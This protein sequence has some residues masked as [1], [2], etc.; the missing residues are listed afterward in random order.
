MALGS[1]GI[2]LNQQHFAYLEKKF[3]P[4]KIIH[5]SWVSFYQWACW[6]TMQMAAQMMVLWDKVTYIQQSRQVTKWNTHG[7]NHTTMQKWVMYIV[8]TCEEERRI[9]MARHPTSA[10]S[11]TCTVHLLTVCVCVC[12]YIYTHM[13]THTYIY[14]IRTNEQLAH[15]VRDQKDWPQIKALWNVFK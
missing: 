15:N 6:I 9:S 3:Q 7:C 11:K 8:L 14:S 12:P 1:V 10:V 13:H 2:T 4:I 5:V